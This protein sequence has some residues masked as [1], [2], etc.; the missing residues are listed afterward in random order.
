MALFGGRNRGV[1]RVRGRVHVE[2]RSG[3]LA[4]RYWDFPTAANVMVRSGCTRNVADLKQPP[5]RSPSPRN[6]LETRPVASSNSKLTFARGGD[7]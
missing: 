5:V 4:L 3:V 2:Y 1:G 7:A 6:A